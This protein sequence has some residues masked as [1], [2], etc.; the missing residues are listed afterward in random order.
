MRSYK[1]AWFTKAAR[2][3]RISDQELDKAIA[4]VALGQADDLGGGVFKR[5]L[6]K[7]EHRTIIL[8]K[9]ED[10][11]VYEYV[12]AKKDRDNIDEA[13][14]KAFRALAKTYATLTERQIAAL[15]ENK[16]WI[17]IIRETTK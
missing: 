10:F 7:N 9:A 12:F 5:R 8:S 14:L 16:D 17:E 11:W 15:M 4:Q 2:K 3:A 6:N 13:E 1:T